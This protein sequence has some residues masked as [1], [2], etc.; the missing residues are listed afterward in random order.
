MAWQ[1]KAAL[2]LIVLAVVVVL[3]QVALKRLQ[4]RYRGVVTGAPQALRDRF[5][6]WRLNPNYRRIDIQHNRGGFRRTDEVSIIKPPGTVRIFL[7]GGSAVYG[8]QGAYPQ[9]ES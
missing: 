4:K 7:L 9:I 2:I 3:L 6:A 8:A 1:T 5:V